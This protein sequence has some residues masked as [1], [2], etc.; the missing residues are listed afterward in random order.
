M[1]KVITVRHRNAS[2]QLSNAAALSVFDS[3][4]EK[5]D[6]ARKARVTRRNRHLAW[7]NHKTHAEHNFSV[8]SQT[9]HSNAFL[10]RTCDDLL[11]ALQCRSLH[12]DRAGACL[13]RW[14]RLR[15][16]AHAAVVAMKR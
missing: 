3:G 6:G 14:Q 7:R 15:S 12:A 16:R 11:L 9:A 8:L 1:V 5:D 10:K 2:T 4:Q 13:R